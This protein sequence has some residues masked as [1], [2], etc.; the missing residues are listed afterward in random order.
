MVL[1]S[2]LGDLLLGCFELKPLL[3]H[4][5][6]GVVNLTALA[7]ILLLFLQGL[8]LERQEVLLLYSQG[9]LD[10]PQLL[11]LLGGSLLLSQKL[12]LL[13]VGRGPLLLQGE[14]PLVLQLL[15]LVL[16]LLPQLLLLVQQGHLLC[17]QRLAEVRIHFSALLVQVLKH[18]LHTL[19]LLLQVLLEGH[20]LP[21]KV[22]TLLHK[23][24]LLL[25]E[26]LALDL[27][28]VPQLV[29]LRALRPQHE[30]LGLHLP[31]GI[32]PRTVDLIPALGQ[33]VF[34]LIDA[35]PLTL[36]LF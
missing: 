12:G 22:H 9:L 7:I 20:P 6:L 11:N 18:D 36:Q 31:L 14:Q 33:I 15:L 21:L 2:L 30:A 34:L 26:L 16:D 5:P 27:E 25:V 1:S 23:S 17:V 35:Q 24:L 8:L 4:L 28:A 10:L 13:G 19:L 3:L 32:L 29:Q